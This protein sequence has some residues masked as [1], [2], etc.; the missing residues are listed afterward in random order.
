MPL[1]SGLKQLGGRKQRSKPR[2]TIKR[3]IKRKRSKINKR[4]YTRVKE[5]SDNNINEISLNKS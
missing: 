1:K 5:S 3:T 4:G 2:R